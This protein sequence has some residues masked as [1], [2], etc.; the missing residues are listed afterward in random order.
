MESTDDVL[1][2]AAQAGEA[3]AF[4]RL[5]ER[6]Y[7]H[8]LRYAWRQLG[9]RADAEEV[10]QDAVLRAYRGLAR[11]QPERFRAW[12]LTIVVNQCRTQLARQ[13][14]RFLLLRRW[15]QG[16]L[17]T[18]GAIAPVT[19]GTEAEELLRGLPDLLREAFLLKHVEDLTYEQM[20][21]VTGATVSALKMRVKRAADLLAERVAHERND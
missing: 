8:C 17:S 2:R 5:I 21:E 9:N 16:E 18:N 10:V 13:R 3:A 1:V 14:R 4:D 11:A 15:W 12:L 19:A 7:E 20:A 6:H